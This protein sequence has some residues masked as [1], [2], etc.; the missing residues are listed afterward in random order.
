MLALKRPH[1]NKTSSCCILRV[2]IDILGKLAILNLLYYLPQ[3]SIYFK[4]FHQYLNEN[5]IFG[6]KIVNFGRLFLTFLAVF[7]QHL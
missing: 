5:G 7:E 3:N 4:N 2:L 1:V 6:Q